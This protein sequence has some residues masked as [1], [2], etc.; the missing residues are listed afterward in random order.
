MKRILII[1]MTPVLGGVETY[2]YNLVKNLDKKKYYIDFLIIGYEKPVFEN[3][4]NMFF[5]DGKEHFFYIPN[6]KHNYFKAKKCIKNFYNKNRY[7]IIY[8][9]TCTAAKINY[10]KFAIK[11]YG[12]ILITHSHSGNATLKIHAFNNKLYRKYITKKSMVKLACSEVAYRWLF[13][14]EVKDSCI[15]PNGVDISRFSFNQNWRNEIRQ[16]LNIKDD[17]IVIGNVGRFSPEKNQI[18]FT[19]LC[20]KTNKKV[21]FLI[22]GDGE[23]K[24]EL[25]NKI[26]TD[27]LQDRF[28][29]LPAC[30]DI[31]KYYSAMDIFAMPSK[32]EGL[33]IV[34]MEAQ[35]TGLPCIL[36]SNISKQT[37]LSKYC[38]IVELEKIDEWIKFIKE[39]SG[40]RYDGADLIQH[41][42][43]DSMKP[44]EILN[45]IFKM[46]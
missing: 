40:I 35:A 36:S 46:L 15:V 10:C 12:T 5:E 43:F 13:T 34:A 4:I 20:K 32:F 9:N 14:D 21:V 17:D 25:M 8:L 42:G 2:I 45:K 27:G 39:F 16:N 26:K 30:N 1:G 11:K 31:E 23:L 29:I 18:Y 3:E 44:V 24:Q 7:E 6:L 37:S 33:P 19:E 41:K 28:F 38:K 22:I